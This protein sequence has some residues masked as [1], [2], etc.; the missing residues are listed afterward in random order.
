MGI[1][2]SQAAYLGVLIETSQK[3]LN[4]LRQLISVS[5]SAVLGLA[6]LVEARKDRLLPSRKIKVQ[7]VGSKL[8]RVREDGMGFDFD[9]P[10][11]RHLI[12]PLSAGDAIPA[13]KSIDAFLMVGRTKCRFSPL[14]PLSRKKY[15]DR[16][17]Q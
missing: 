8:V 10:P 11:H 15:R 12:V 14:Q 9:V 1:V 4:S 7:R 2:D 6:L 13:G 17:E 5:W 3:A 16:S